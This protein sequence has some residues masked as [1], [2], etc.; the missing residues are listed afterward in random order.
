MAGFYAA[1][2]LHSREWQ[3][4]TRAAGETAPWPGAPAE[5]TADQQLLWT[6]HQ[7]YRAMISAVATRKGDLPETEILEHPAEFREWFD[8]WIERESRSPGD[9]REE[10]GWVMR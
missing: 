7:E 2:V 3:R 8:D 6:I 9:K 1:V 10:H 4:I 5:W